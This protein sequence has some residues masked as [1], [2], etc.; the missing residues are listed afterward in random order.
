[1]AEVWIVDLDRRCIE[2]SAA[3]GGR[4]IEEYRTVRW[5]PAGMSH[6]LELSIEAMLRDI[7]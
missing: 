3:G 2:V 6:A 5:Q 7:V 4:S 1:M